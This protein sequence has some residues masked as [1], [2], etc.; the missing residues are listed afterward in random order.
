[1]VNGITTIRGG[2]HVDNVINQ[3]VKKLSEA[4][5]KKKRRLILSLVMLRII[6]GFLLSVLL[7]NQHLM[8]R[9]RKV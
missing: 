3:I 9:L 8:V 1:M 2:K 7:R 4:V 6:F 5:L